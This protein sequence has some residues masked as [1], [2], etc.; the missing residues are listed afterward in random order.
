MASKFQPVGRV[1]L[2]REGSWWVARWGGVDE[3]EGTIELARV[4]TALAEAD[5]D[6]R[7]LFIDL[8]KRMMSRAIRD[9]FDIEAWWGDPMPDPE[10]E[11]GEG[12]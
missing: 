2:R 12:T 4:R 10:R 7:Q 3:S 11:P 1:M 9:V 6:L 5:D 8:T